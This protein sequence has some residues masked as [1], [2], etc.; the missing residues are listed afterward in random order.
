VIDFSSS[1]GEML[2]RILEDIGYEIKKRLKDEIGV[3]MHCNIGIGTNRFLAKTA[4][5][6]HK[7]DG[8]DVLTSHNIHEIFSGMKLQDL[9]GI[10]VQNERRLNSV[11]IYTPIAMLE[12]SSDALHMAFRSIHGEQWFKRLRGWEVDDIVYDMKSCG[13]QYVLDS[14][15]L[16]RAEI[17]QRLHNLVEGVGSK[18]R[19]YG[20]AARGV[21]L[22]THNF[23]KGS[24][25]AR[26]L[27]PLPFFSDQAIWRIAERLFEGAPDDII[28][29][30]VSCD[31]LQ[32]DEIDQL[33]IF[34]DE[35]ARERRIVTAVD[36]V[37]LRYGERTIY[38][39]DTAETNAYMRAKIPFGSTRYM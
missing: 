31:Y 5:G 4:A 38:S 6:L 27:S 22:Y 32:D 34:G 16:S 35:I 24:W 15:N 36:E 13:R 3:W 30:S 23:P 39:A 33:S 7:P 9:T 21:S 14:R 28:M 8:L 1:T 2:G 18:L 29:I 17:M 11:G 19:R 26:Q 37:N 10:A 12:S 20:K 25:R